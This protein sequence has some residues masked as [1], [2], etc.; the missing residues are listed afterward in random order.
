[1]ARTPPLPAA[2]DVVHYPLTVPVPR[3]KLPRVV[4]LHDLQH[5]ELPEYFSRGERAFRRLAYEG[6]ARRADVVV[7]ATEHARSMLAERVG[8]DPGRVVVAPHGVD[9]GRFHLG[10]SDEVPFDLPERF[11]YYPANL[12]PH[13]NHAR[14]VEAW[15]R[16]RDP[17]CLVLAG[18][19]YGRLP[20]LLELARRL[21]VAGRVCHVGHV[22]AATLAALYRQAQ[23]V[24]FPSLYEGFGAPPLEAMACG[25]PVAASRR[26]S[27][28]EVCGDAAAELEPDDPAQMAAAL[29]RLLGDEEE[30]ARL[31]GRGLERAPEF[32]W[33]RAAERHL[34]VYARAL[35]AAGAR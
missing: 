22:D 6:A 35:E 33:R 10:A 5:L 23:A 4:T 15:A 27:L 1:M 26:A 31:R 2:I 21:G 18:Q 20:G 32:T 19:P 14:L 28:A 12:W 25:C 9:H 7:T 8:V 13:K 34:G 3:T 24:A 30:R 11:L 29:E 16:V 17:A